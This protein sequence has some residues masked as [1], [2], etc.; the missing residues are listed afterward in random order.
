MNDEVFRLSTHI[1][2]PAGEVFSWHLRPGA[3]ERLSPP[4]EPITVVS[5]SGPLGEGMRAVIRTG[6]GIARSEWEV[7]HDQFVA[8]T[9]FRDVMIRGPFA[10]WEH[11]HAVE[12]EGDGASRL[13]DTVT[14]RLPLG[15]AGRIAAGGW[16][17]RRIE[18]VFA[19]RHAVTQG[20]LESVAGYG[21]VPP[22]T[23]AMAGASGLLGSA[24][25]PFLR[26]QGHR[27]VVLVRRAA[28][29]PDEIGW[30]PVAG[31]IEAKQL[32]GIDAVVNL[33]GENIGAGRWTSE[34]RQAIAAS[35]LAT[36]RTL[37]A[38]IGQ[39]ARA[40]RVLVNAS[41]VGVYGD[42]G[43]SA[44]AEDAPAADG[45]LAKVV[46]DWEQAAQAAEK[47]GT[48]V[49]LARFGVVLSPAGGALAKL[50]PF[51]SAGLGGPVGSGRQWM[52]WLSVDD[53]V[54]AVYH[55]LVTP[56]LAGP[57]NL[58]APGAVANREFAATLGRILRRPAILP[59]PAGVLRLGF[60]EMADATV[61]ASTRVR[62]DRLTD[63]GY[64]FRY[65][66]LDGAL[67]HVLGRMA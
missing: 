11:V 28:R 29:S 1:R 41:A 57:V 67:R 30:D 45:F 13:T 20:D 56:S 6:S 54:G 35:R 53:A 7:R 61:L 52:S 58:A 55:A 10:R 50:L 42:T 32:E 3:L 33:A 36:T 64:R 40:P 27:V 38:A 31:R 49:V 51:F 9:R 60:G 4:W 43:D 19:W 12:P 5:R 48:R 59:V 65:A 21:V 34:R 2:R 47:W 39:L 25:V 16:V 37:V 18:R 44:V 46:R 15:V 17:R 14:Y 26:T 24:L 8:G 63:S 22:M 62:A 66:E 23:I